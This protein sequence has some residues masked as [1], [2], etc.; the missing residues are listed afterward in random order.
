MYP[1]DFEEE[2][3]EAEDIALS[4][5]DL[6]QEDTILNDQAQWESMMNLY[7]HGLETE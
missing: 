7:E 4:S 5:P 3:T 6:T 2:L 1:N